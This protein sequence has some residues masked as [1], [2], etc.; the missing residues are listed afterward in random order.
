MLS[1]PDTFLP[2]LESLEVFTS[3]TI[4]VFGIFLTPFDLPTLKDLTV[5]SRFGAAWVGMLSARCLCHLERVRFWGLQP[6]DVLKF[7]KDAPLIEE[8]SFHTFVLSSFHEMIAAIGCGDLV[9]ALRVFD[10]NVRVA[11]AMLLPMLK[12]RGKFVDRSPSQYATLESI[13]VH[14]A[15]PGRL[16]RSLDELGDRGVGIAFR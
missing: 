2:C 8:W 14:G 7:I 13:V 9:P 10:C 5:M 11:D 15:P 1:M 3:S 12:T 4:G 6:Q 16:R